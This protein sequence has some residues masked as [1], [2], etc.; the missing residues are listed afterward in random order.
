MEFECN[1]ENSQAFMAARWERFARLKG[2]IIQAIQEA[3]ADSADKARQ[4]G[5]EPFDN[6]EITS[7]IACAVAKVVGKPCLPDSDWYAEYPDLTPEHIHLQYDVEEVESLIDDIRQ[8]MCPNC[9][10]LFYQ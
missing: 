6:A 8:A 3:V 1:P 5:W 4:R 2:R 9:S 10:I 7:G